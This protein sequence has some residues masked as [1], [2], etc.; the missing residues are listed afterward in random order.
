MMCR[1]VETT[2]TKDGV[3]KAKLVKM[4]KPISKDEWISVVPAE[5]A[6][7]GVALH[8]VYD[9]SLDVHT[10]EVSWMAREL[11][12][13]EN[14]LTV[15][16]WL[17]GMSIGFGMEC[18][19]SLFCEELGKMPEKGLILKLPSVYEPVVEVEYKG[20]VGRVKVGTAAWVPWGFVVVRG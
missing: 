2:M 5:V 18:A 20:Q 11:V 14:E 3:R 7:R 19:A 17:G 15:W 13:R 16:W 9:P 6:L 10:L 8:E 12:R 1:I 4:G